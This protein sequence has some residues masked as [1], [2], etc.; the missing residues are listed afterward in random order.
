MGVVA[1][2]LQGRFGNQMFTYAYARAYAERVGAEFQCEPWIGQRIFAIEDRPVGNPDLPRRDEHS[3]VD[4]EHDICIRTY[5]QNQQCVLYSRPQLKGWFTF[6]PEILA[7]LEHA[8]ER[9]PIV[10]HRR[11]GD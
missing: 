6:R 7:A 4:G 1:A 8:V 11:V 10:A 3:L 9:W 2:S 5:A